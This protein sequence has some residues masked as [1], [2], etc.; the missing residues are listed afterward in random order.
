MVVQLPTKNEGILFKMF[1]LKVLTEKKK[2]AQHE[3]C[4]LSS[5]GDK[6]GMIAL[7]KVS[8]IAL[9]NWQIHCS[10]AHILAE[11]CCQSR[12]ICY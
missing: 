7:K 11:G 3:N 4:E 9:R 6:I 8:Q 12:D 5:F 2:N 1:S 10:Q